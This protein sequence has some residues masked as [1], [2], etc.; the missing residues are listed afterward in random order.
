MD[1]NLGSLIAPA[2]SKTV[3]AGPEVSVASRRRPFSTKLSRQE[4]IRR[5]TDVGFLL[6]QP[7]GEQARGFLLVDLPTST[8]STV[9]DSGRSS[10]WR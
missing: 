2:W 3:Q 9:Q 4:P 10:S 1:N 7:R 5:V 6:Y 8:Q